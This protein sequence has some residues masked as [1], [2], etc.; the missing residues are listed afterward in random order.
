M[1]LEEP[2]GD[3]LASAPVQDGTVDMPRNPVGEENADGTIDTSGQVVVGVEPADFSLN[4]HPIDVGAGGDRV[5]A[6]LTQLLGPGEFHELEAQMSNGAESVHAPMNAAAALSLIYRGRQACVDQVQPILFDNAALGKLQ[7]AKGQFFVRKLGQGKFGTVVL[8][9][10]RDAPPETALR[11][12]KVLHTPVDEFDER[13]GMWYVDSE[14]NAVLSQV[15]R[16]SRDAKAHKVLGEQGVGVSPEL[17][18]R[19]LVE[20]H[21]GKQH[22][23]I[24]MKY[25]P[26]HTLGAWMT[27]A[28]K[29]GRVPLPLMADM[30]TL[31]ATQFAKAHGKR[32]L[33]RDVSPGN[34]YLPDADMVKVLDWGLSVEPTGNERF[35]QQHTIMGTPLYM[36]PELATDAAGVSYPSDV[37]QLAAVLYHANMGRPLFDGKGKANGAQMM[38]LLEQHRNDVPDLTDF[39]W[40]APPALKDL[41]VRALDKD[42]NRRP[43]MEQFAEGLYAASNLRQRSGGKPYARLAEADAEEALRLLPIPDELLRKRAELERDQPIP[44]WY[45]K[46]NPGEAPRPH[47]GVEQMVA[48]HLSR[49]AGDVQHATRARLRYALGWTGGVVAVGTGLALTTWAIVSSASKPDVPAPSPDAATALKTPAEV[50]VAPKSKPK[51]LFAEADERGRVKDL[52]MFAGLP[53]EVKLDDG[54]AVLFTAD[55]KV[56]A[57]LAKLDGDGLARILGYKTR[58]DIPENELRDGCPAIVFTDA[59]GRWVLMLNGVA[60]VTGR[61]EP[62]RQGTAGHVYSDR[63]DIKKSLLRHGFV[64][65]EHAGEYLR[66]EDLGSVVRSMPAGLET[67]DPDDVGVNGERRGDSAVN[68]SMLTRSLRGAL[69]KEADKK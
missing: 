59:E 10:D 67:A 63:A 60:Y 21:D 50:V 24:S 33:H 53:C 37:Y 35:T 22:P 16:F 46:P 34:L 56:R 69:P 39:G 12:M 30:G 27:A 57:A 66:D 9:F 4:V 11:V 62:D 19:G 7:L 42:P 28:H 1:S 64:P 41:F 51:R 6:R 68:I 5:R 43:T 25:V 14:D 18:G 47:G 29:H 8:I 15:A 36:S 44:S 40:Y 13:T 49:T 3:G 2:T 32:H 20:W 31:F 17:L 45:A 52:R 58:D 48:F 54:N 55:Q 26:G 61:A 23:Y 38:A 65:A